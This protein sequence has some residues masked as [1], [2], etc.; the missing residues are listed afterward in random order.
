MIRGRPVAGHLV[1]IA[2]IELLKHLRCILRIDPG[3]MRQ[4]HDVARQCRH[5]QK[6]EVSEEF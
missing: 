3:R 4:S 1:E 2:R 5:A 6:R